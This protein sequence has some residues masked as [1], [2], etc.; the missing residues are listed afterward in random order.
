[1]TETEWLTS[2]DPAA[3]LELL[4]P[5]ISDRKLRLFMTNCHRRL[6]HRLTDLER[7]MPEATEQ[8]L[9]GKI[10]T[11]QFDAAYIGNPLFADS[12]APT[13]EEYT[14]ERALAE[15]EYITEYADD[16]DAEMTAQAVLLREIFG[17]PFRRLPV[18]AAWRS[19]RGGAVVRLARA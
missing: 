14:L 15:V 16:A 11:A 7:R 18:K 9:Q 12:H 4:A 6:W 19:H 10:T 2:T 3:M 17:N 5:R 1:M 8:Y 13:P